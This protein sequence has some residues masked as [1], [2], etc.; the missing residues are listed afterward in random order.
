MLGLIIITLSLSLLLRVCAP[1]SCQ[2][3]APYRGFQRPVAPCLEYCTKIQV[4]IK[5][6]DHHFEIISDLFIFS[7]YLNEDKKNA[8]FQIVSDFVNFVPKVN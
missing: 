6:K 1:L 2:K 8:S 5:K 4:K 7:Q 3:M